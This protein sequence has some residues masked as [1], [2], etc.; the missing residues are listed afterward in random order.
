MTAQSTP[1]VKD[2][3]RTDENSTR[4]AAVLRELH[5]LPVNGLSDSYLFTVDAEEFSRLDVHHSMFSA[6]LGRL[7]PPPATDAIQDALKVRDGYARPA[8]LDIGTGSGAWSIDMAKAF[9]NVAVVGMDLVP[10]K[11]S[12][13][14]PSNCRFEV[15]NADTD[16]A[17]MYD[18]ESFNFIHARSMMSGVKDF[19]TFF[20]NVWRMLRPGGVFVAVD[21]RLSTW[22][23]DR[24]EIEYKEEGEPGFN[25]FRK[26]LYHMH[27]VLAAR[28]PNAELM[29]RITDCVRG[30]GDDLWGKVDT[31]YLYLPVGNFDSPTMSPSERVGGK[32][33]TESLS[34]LLNS[35]RPTLL[36]SSLTPEGVD[37][38]TTELRAELKEPKVKQFS[39]FIFTW[40]V[41]K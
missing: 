14:P 39:Q 12:C 34:M 10:V 26:M 24:Q 17:K 13:P 23:E 38:L 33:F 37:R 3:P 11:P 36:S 6:A 8:V 41:K 16:L 20:Q 7:F 25:W 4:S 5:G 32:L 30:M 18:A 27:E 22:D 28:N 9:P 15:G 19:P 1:D 2:S 40:A 21:L 31:F 29:Y 35:I